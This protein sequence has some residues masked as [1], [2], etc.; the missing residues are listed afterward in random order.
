MRDSFFILVVSFLVAAAAGKPSFTFRVKDRSLSDMNKVDLNNQNVWGRSKNDATSSWET[1]SDTIEP[2]SETDDD[3]IG[4]F[5]SRREE[6]RTL[7]ESDAEKS[8][9]TILEEI[10]ETKRE[11][12]REMEELRA[13]A[14]DF[15]TV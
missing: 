9:L 13:E 4:L 2:T 1:T 10:R 6:A 12:Q 11:M 3:R 8:I 14:S 7:A 15:M 5:A